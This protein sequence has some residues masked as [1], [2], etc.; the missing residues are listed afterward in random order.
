[1]Y[2][3]AI[4]PR[5]KLYRPRFHSAGWNLF[6]PTVCRARIGKRYEKFVAIVAVAVMAE[7]AT[8]DPITAV[9]MAML[10]PKTN[11]AALTGI[12]FLF[13]RRKYFENGKTPS[14]EMAKV[15]RWALI[16]QLAVAQ[17]ESTHNKLKIA[18][19]PLAPISCTRY[20]AQLLEYAALTIPSKSCKQNRIMIRVGTDNSQA[21]RVLIHMPFA[22]TIEAS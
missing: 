7:K 9:V 5:G 16:K 18:T 8:T 3:T 12:L 11:K 6:L 2:N 17:V 10:S 4:T 21:D 13:R 19:A 1:M 22:T 20:S 14:R 15:T